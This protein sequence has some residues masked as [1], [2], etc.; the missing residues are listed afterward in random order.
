MRLNAEVN[1]ILGL[2]E[3]REAQT[4]VGAQPMP[5]TVAAFGEFLARDIERQ[6]DWIR[7]ARIEAS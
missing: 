1:R 3:T 4:R 5:M 6:R 2:A 7:M